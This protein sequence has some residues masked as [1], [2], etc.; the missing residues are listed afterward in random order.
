M[1]DNYSNVGISAGY[2]R[3]NSQNYGK[4]GVDC[5]YKAELDNPDIGYTLSGN[6]GDLIGKKAGLNGGVYAGMDFMKTTCTELNVGVMAD[7]TKAFD[8]NGTVQNGQTVVADLDPKQSLKVGGSLGFTKN[9]CCDDDRQFSMALMGGAEFHPNPQ[10]EAD[11][12]IITTQNKTS[13]FMG[14]KSEYSTKIND[15]GQQLVF[16]GKCFV[17]EKGSTYGEASIGFRF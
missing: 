13:A 14:V 3:F 4:V 9:I 8:E 5:K 11:N 1:G 7:Y 10:Y 17:S 6:A 16:G 2:A 12:K 15:K